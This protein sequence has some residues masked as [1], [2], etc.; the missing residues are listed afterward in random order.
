[1]HQ[2]NGLLPELRDQDSWFDL[3]RGLVSRGDSLIRGVRRVRLREAVVHTMLRWLLLGLAAGMMRGG[4]N[5]GEE[6]RTAVAGVGWLGAAARIVLLVMGRTAV[7]GVDS[8]VLGNGWFESVVVRRE[9]EH[10]VDGL[11]A[12]ISSVDR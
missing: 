9:E 7:V 4:R 5:S 3:C 2:R 1:M 6:V 11:W 12:S 10:S 8:I